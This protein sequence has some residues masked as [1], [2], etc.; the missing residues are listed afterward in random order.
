MNAETDSVSMVVVVLGPVA[1]TAL[2]AAF[3][4]WLRTRGQ[5]RG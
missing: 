2:I 5:R 4:F 1:V 3:V